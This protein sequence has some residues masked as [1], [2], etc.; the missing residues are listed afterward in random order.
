MWSHAAITSPYAR[1]LVTQDM[2]FHVLEALNRMRLP[3]SRLHIFVRWL[4]FATPPEWVRCF[5]FLHASR[6]KQI[7][8]PRNAA[9]PLSVT[10]QTQLSIFGVSFGLCLHFIIQYSTPSVSALSRRLDLSVSASTLSTSG[11]GLVPCWEVYQVTQWQRI[12]LSAQEQQETWL[13]SLSQEDPL[14]KEMAAHSSILAWRIPWTEESGGFS[15]W[16]SRVRPDW[17]TK[18]AGSPLSWDCP[19]HCGMF[20]SIPG[21]YPADTSQ[22]H[23]SSWL[24]QPEVSP[25]IAICPPGTAWRKVASQGQSSLKRQVVGW[26]IPKCEWEVRSRENSTWALLAFRL[27]LSGWLGET[28]GKSSDVDQPWQTLLRRHSGHLVPSP[29]PTASPASLQPPPKGWASTRAWRWVSKDVP[30]SLVLKPCLGYTLAD[31]S[32]KRGF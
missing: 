28:T 21:F 20:V 2:I 22:S 32:F 26:V 1:S 4:T 16:G 9:L 6:M 23:P 18:H 17:A 3:G 13:G 11:A 14:E 10:L 31:L 24:W 30:D 15:P 29:E 27:A 5:S 12:R 19:G 7:P 8:S 25:D